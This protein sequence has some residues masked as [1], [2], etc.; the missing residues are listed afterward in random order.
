MKLFGELPGWRRLRGRSFALLWQLVSRSLRHPVR[1]PFE[2]T[3]F[4]QGKNKYVS[5]L[6]KE[7]PIFALDSP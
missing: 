2:K 6:S 1:H 7:K 3:M 4:W 5:N